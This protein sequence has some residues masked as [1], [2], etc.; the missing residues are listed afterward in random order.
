MAKILIV[1][2]LPLN[3]EYLEEQLHM[4]NHEV[5]TAQDGDEALAKVAQTDPDLILLDFSMPKKDGLEVLKILRADPNF[6][7]LPIIMLTAKK[8]Y[9][10][11]I[12][13]LDAGADDYITKPFHMGEVA[14]RIKA[15]L[16]LRDLRKQVVDREKHLSQVQGVGQTMVTLAHHIN[17]AT[18]AISGMAQLCKHDPSDIKQHHQMAKISYVQAQKI[19]AVIHALQEMVEHMNIKTAEYA[20]SP[21]RMFDIEDKI[22][23]RLQEI[24]KELAE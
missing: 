17:N 21:D 24:E 16:R 14:A 1:D 11:R 8:E 19:S 13:G 22:Q 23:K 20:G 7:G 10:D 12:A 5:V 4:L 18:Q 15:M 2:D 6:E 9:E 3:I